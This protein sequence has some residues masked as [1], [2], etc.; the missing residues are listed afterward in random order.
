MIQKS[1]IDP[2]SVTNKG[3]LFY[4]H[5]TKVLSSCNGTMSLTM[6]VD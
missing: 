6:F 2:V 5:E 1:S 3:L 4:L